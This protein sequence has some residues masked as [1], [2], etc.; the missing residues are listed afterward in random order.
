M[1]KQCEWEYSNRNRCPGDA[2]FE[3]KYL[4]QGP[5]RDAV[6]CLN[7]AQRELSSLG[8]SFRML[9]SN[10]REEVNGIKKEV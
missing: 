9:S 10:E 3:V 2:L 6:F 4:R 7:H 1:M 5:N 8:I